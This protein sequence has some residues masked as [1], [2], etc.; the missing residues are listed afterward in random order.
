[1]S[2]ASIQLT[3]SS[4]LKSAIKGIFLRKLRNISFAA[5]HDSYWTHAGKVEE[6]NDILRDQFIN[7]HSQP[8]LENLKKSFERRF[9]QITFPDIP[10]RGTFDLEN[11]RKSVFFFS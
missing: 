1:L 4:Q 2:T 9:P 7:L 3:C 6:M 8:I 11:V 10:E 5:V